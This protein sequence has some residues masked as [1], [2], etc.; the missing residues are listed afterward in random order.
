MLRHLSRLNPSYPPWLV[1]FAS[2][3]NDKKIKAVIDLKP[4]PPINNNRIEGVIIAI[5]E[6]SLG[7]LAILYESPDGKQ[8]V[9]VY[10]PNAIN[11]T[12]TCRRTEDGYKFCHG[13]SDFG[14]EITSMTDD[15]FANGQYG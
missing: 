7:N 10:L 5:A 15:I 11:A 4:T 2:M 13:R 9:F 14:G 8:D 12:F 6:T 3:V 1:V